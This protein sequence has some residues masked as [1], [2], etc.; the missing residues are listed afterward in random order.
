MILAGDIPENS[1]VQLMMTNVDTIV[2]ASERAAKQ[3]N[4]SRENKAELAILISCIGR[5]LVL[6]QRVK[7]EIEEVVEVLGD[8]TT[9]CGFY[10]YGEIAP[11]DGDT[12]CQLHNQ[13]M[14]ITLMSE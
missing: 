9:I 8:Q 6:D 3:A 2:S 11:F 5:K 14:T 13:T 7:E 1:K 10:S 12:L 4:S